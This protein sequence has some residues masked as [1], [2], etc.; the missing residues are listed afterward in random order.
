LRSTAVRDVPNI[1][2]VGTF[3]FGPVSVSAAAGFATWTRGLIDGIRQL[4]GSGE[5]RPIP[6]FEAVMAI[7][8]K[9]LSA[10][11]ETAADHRRSGRTVIDAVQ[12]PM[13]ANEWRQLHDV[14]RAIES[15][16]GLIA[17]RGLLDLEM[18]DDE[19]A[20]MAALVEGT[21]TGG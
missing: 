13:T 1:P 2:F 18:T 6:H 19:A 5:I 21:H 16:V 17:T 8:A 20:A 14:G 11:D 15:Y 4:E 9:V 10:V 7:Y 12:V 3:R